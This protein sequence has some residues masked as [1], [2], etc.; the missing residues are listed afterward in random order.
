MKNLRENT[1][2][3][4]S[5]LMPNLTSEMTLSAESTNYDAAKGDAS[6]VTGRRLFGTMS[7]ELGD[8][9]IF[10]G[11]AGFHTTNAQN[12]ANVMLY[13]F[14]L[15]HR[16][17]QMLQ[18]FVRTRQELIDDTM[19]SV[20]R[21]YSRQGYE[22]GMELDAP[23]GFALGTDFAFNRLEAGNNETRLN[24]WAGYSFF[25]EFSTV[26]LKYEY[27]LARQNQ[28][29]VLTTD[30][31]TGESHNSLSYW[32]P[33]NYWVQ[34]ASASYR[35]LL[36]GLGF[37]GQNDSYCSLSL[38]TGYESGDSLLTTGNFDISLELSRH[39]LLK[40]NILFAKSNDFQEEGGFISLVYRW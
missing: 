4:H 22:G 27:L 5:W 8:N 19:T 25:G 40:G 11:G 1:V 32:S 17:D 24:L 39:F 37:P 38:S 13:D 29:G 20:T 18:G 2:G 35:Y 21:G 15:R 31:L 26:S 14:A 23:S 16:F 34:Q 36:A 3:L 28:A 6:G 10:T 9:N 33:G 30:P 12:G 7:I